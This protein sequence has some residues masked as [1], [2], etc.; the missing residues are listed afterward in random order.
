M[1][2]PQDYTVGWICAILTEYVA[3]CEFFDEEHEDLGSLPPNEN[4]TYTLGK[5]GK[6]NVAIAVPSDGEYGTS[7]ANNVARDMLCSF[8]NI[9]Q[10]E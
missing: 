10:D 8:S 9:C 6:H 2:N 3:A 5:V 1:S 7:S 4:N